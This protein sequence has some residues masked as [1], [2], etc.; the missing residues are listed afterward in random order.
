[1]VN[2][3]IQSSLIIHHFSI[4]HAFVLLPAEVRG[5]IHQPLDPIIPRRINTCPALTSLLE[6]NPVY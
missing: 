2:P 3:L 5:Q 4:I 6:N 1:M